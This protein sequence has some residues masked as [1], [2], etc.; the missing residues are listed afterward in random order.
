MLLCLFSVQNCA[1]L[2]VKAQDRVISGYY[3]IDPDKGGPLR[4]FTVWCDTDS[5][6]AGITVLREYKFVREQVYYYVLYSAAGK[7][8]RFTISR[9]TFSHTPKPFSQSCVR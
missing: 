9:L 4:P 1:D 3:G 5:D 6:P 7:Q 2:V 8:S